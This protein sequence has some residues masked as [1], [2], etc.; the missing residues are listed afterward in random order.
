MLHILALIAM[1]GIIIY[2]HIDNLKFFKKLDRIA[3]GEKNVN[4]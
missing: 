2:L 1:F 3:K 4:L